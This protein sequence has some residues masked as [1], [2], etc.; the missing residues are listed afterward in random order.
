ME[1]ANGYQAYWKIS[2]GAVTTESRI[3]YEGIII[4]IINKFA[5]IRSQRYLAG[6]QDAQLLSQ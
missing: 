2:D 6:F 1:T 5:E 3:K 4:S